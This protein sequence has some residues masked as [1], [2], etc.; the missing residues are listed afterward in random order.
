MRFMGGAEARPPIVLVGSDSLA[1]RNAGKAADQLGLALRMVGSLEQVDGEPAAVVVG[2]GGEGSLPTVA[3]SKERWPHAMVVGW[4]GTPDPA[5]W[6]QA[7]EAGCDAVTSRGALARTLAERLPAWLAEPGGRRL[8]LLPTGDLAG[9]LGL[10]L[11]MPDTPL[12]PLAVYHIAGELL[13]ID[14]VCPHA[15]ARLSEGEL[16]MDQAV[17]TCPEH[18]SRFSTRSG[19]RLRGPADDPIR[20]HRVLIQDG[21][22]YLRLD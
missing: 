6:E 3:S 22:A 5:L 1:A 15:G 12:G 10:V 11:R 4:V 14:D 18:G 17:V 7:E 8:R 13:V 19:E 16:D 21:T 9:R 2:L 20:T